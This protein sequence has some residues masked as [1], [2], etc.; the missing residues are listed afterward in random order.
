MLCINWKKK[1]LN[2]FLK[3]YWNWSHTVCHCTLCVVWIK[4]VEEQKSG[5]VVRFSFLVFPQKWS[6]KLFFTFFLPLRTFHIELEEKWLR[7]NT[8][9]WNNTEYCGLLNVHCRL[10]IYLNTVYELQIR[11]LQ[12]R[13]TFS[14]RRSVNHDFPSEPQNPRGADLGTWGNKTL[15]LSK[16]MLSRSVFVRFGR[17][18]ST[19]CSLAWTWIAQKTE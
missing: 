11:R 19:W 5:S 2:L 1:A 6:D 9:L 10:L 13:G 7:K 18:R 12:I 15:L 16:V 8:R 17:C 3:L 4:L 14:G